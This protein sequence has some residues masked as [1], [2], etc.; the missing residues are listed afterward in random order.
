[1]SAVSRVP[2]SARDIA[3]QAAGRRVVGGERPRSEPAGEVT[4]TGASLIEWSPMRT[5]I[6][7]VQQA[8]PGMCPVL[9]N[10]ALL[11]ASGQTAGASSVLQQGVETDPEAKESPLAWLA[12]FDLLNRANDRTA[13]DRV[14]LQYVVHFERSAPTW[15]RGDAPD[16]VPAARPVAGGYVALTGKLTAATAP[17]IEILRRVIARNVANAR[18]DLEAVAG[19]D[20]AGARLLADALA[21]ARK[22]QVPMNIQRAEKIR[23]ALDILVKRGREGGE[24]GWLLSLE[25]LQFEQDQDAFDERAIEYAIAFEQSPPSFEP[26]RVPAPEAVAMS[27]AE[28]AESADGPARPGADVI[29][30]TGVMVGAESEKMARIGEYALGH[31]VIPIDMS[32]VDRID[33]VCAGSLLNAINRVESQ[34]KAVQIV[35]ASP[36]IRTLLLLMGISPRHFVKKPQ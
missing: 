5:S 12:L 15:E 20:D 6:E 33:F 17:Q 26:P 19:F 35:G 16:P 4:V 7:V 24:G 28:E 22:R 10:A 14:A 36:I 31:S 9:E 29:V 21:E 25:F 18:L 32:D 1:M 34:R 27:A 8:N 11:F 2:V 3:S 30:W 23:A 13:F